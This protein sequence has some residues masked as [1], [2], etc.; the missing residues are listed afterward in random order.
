MD[1]DYFIYIINDYY[2]CINKEKEKNFLN[3]IQTSGT[4]DTIMIYSIYYSYSPKVFDKVYR[5]QYIKNLRNKFENVIKQANMYR[6]VKNPQ[7]N[8]LKGLEKNCISVF[9]NLIKT[10]TIKSIDDNS[11]FITFIPNGTTTKNSKGAHLTSLLHLL[12]V[13][14]PKV[15]GRIYNAVNL[16]T[17]ENT[18]YNYDNVMLRGMRKNGLKNAKRIR[19]LVIDRIQNYYNN[20]IKHYRLQNNTET[21]QKFL[22]NSS[23]CLFKQAR[24]EYPENPP[25]NIIVHGADMNTD[26]AKLW[27]IG[28]DGKIVAPE[29]HY[30]VGFHVH[31]NH[32]VGLLHMHIIDLTLLTRYSMH[33]VVKTIPWNYFLV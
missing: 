9:E 13:P 29:A 32:S 18:D 1:L 26:V 2:D 21:L 20:F 23:K 24:K 12:V 16:G 14:N 3:N 17:Y 7:C 6:I 28:S 8:L 15:Y 22:S 5:D 31:P 30:I 4:Y 33:N 27:S 19:P 11:S 25:N 10:N